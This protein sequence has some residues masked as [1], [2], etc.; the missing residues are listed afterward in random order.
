[1]AIFI[2]L[3]DI[4]G[5]AKEKFA[6]NTNPEDWYIRA[7]SVTFNLSPSATD[8]AEQTGTDTG[9]TSTGTTSG[10][11]PAT[12][13]TTGTLATVQRAQQRG[14]NTRSHNIASK[15]DEIQF[16]KKMDFSSSYLADAVAN[17]DSG[18]QHNEPK[19]F[20]GGAVIYVTTS[21][22]EV[23]LKIKIPAYIVTDY[24][25]TVT[26]ESESFST[27]ENITIKFD[28]VSWTYTETDSIGKVTWTSD[29]AWAAPE[30]EA[31]AP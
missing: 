23:M 12:G 25:L 15:G 30:D 11:R 7:D 18:A 20:D 14:A 4:A 29:F 13:G 5:D 6:A 2:F 8:G 31:A 1:M 28:S 16:S 24:S 27:A 17:R 21:Q 3:K 26:S 22:R 9:T 19:I 10:P